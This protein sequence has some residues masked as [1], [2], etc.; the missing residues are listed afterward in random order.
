ML[1]KYRETLEGHN[2]SVAELK[3]RVA[4]TKAAESALKKALSQAKKKVEAAEHSLQR[5]IKK[6]EADKD[7]KPAKKSPTSNASKSA[8]IVTEDEEEVV[9][10]ARVGGVL[11]ILRTTADKRRSH[12]ESKRHNNFLNY[13]TPW[14]DGGDDSEDWPDSLKRSLVMRMQRRRVQITLRPSRTSI[15]SD[16]KMETEKELAPDQNSSAK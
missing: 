6:A 8:K 11:D 15:L 16:V 3:E 14:K 7:A 4:E 13:R 10:K 1:D 5:A 9:A 12:L 2:K